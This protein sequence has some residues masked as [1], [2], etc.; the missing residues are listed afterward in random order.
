MAFAIRPCLLSGKI[1]F[2]ASIIAD[3]PVR[4]KIDS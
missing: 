3:F 4:N 1:W 2:D